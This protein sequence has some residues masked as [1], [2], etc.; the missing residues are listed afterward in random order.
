MVSIDR[1]RAGLV[2]MLAL[3]L[4]AG[5]LFANVMYVNASTEHELSGVPAEPSPEEDRVVAI[6]KLPAEPGDRVSLDWV[7]LGGMN[8]TFDRVDLHIVD[9]GYG[10]LFV[11]ETEP[12]DAYVHRSLTM[13]P[14]Q[15]ISGERVTFVRPPVDEDAPEPAFDFP[16]TWL[17][18]VWVFHVA[19][20]HQLPENETARGLFLHGIDVP[21]A[22]DV[23]ITKA[24]AVDAQPWFYAG[25]GILVLA[26]LGAGALALVPRGEGRE[27]APQ[28]DTEALVSLVDRGESYLA[29]LRN[30]LVVTGGLLFFLG[31]F[32]IV[33]LDDVFL[34]AIAPGGP[35]AG[36]DAWV[37]RG[38]AFVWLALVAT[39]LVLLVVVQRAL[40][41][42]RDGARARPL[43]EG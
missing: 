15:G 31:L 30:L 33:A 43:E 13:S 8:P 1:G 12:V 20:D 5:L 37:T 26:G 10:Q 22:T 38:F 36:W 24:S 19:E 3:A 7:P 9:Q 34:R 16:G 2:A 21:D 18:V 4:L 40:N 35:G 41:R 11:N 6:G 29:N 17:D 14:G 32:G 25:E 23:A 28:T 42:W 39:W 27:D